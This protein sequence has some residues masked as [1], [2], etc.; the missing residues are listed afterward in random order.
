MKINLKNFAGITYLLI[1]SFILRLITIYYYGDDSLEHEWSTLLKNLHNHSTLSFRSFNGVLIPSVYM[2]P[3]Y[4]F[5]LYLIKILTPQS[6]AFTQMVLVFQLVLSILS[7]YIFFKLNNFFFNKN[8]SL[9]NSFLLSIFPLNIYATTQISSVTLQLF[10]LIFF[11]YLFFCLYKSQ[12]YKK[13][14]LFYFSLVSGLLIL[15]RGEFYLIFIF[16]LLYLL[17]FKKLNIKYIIIIFLISVIVISPYIIRNYYVFNKITLTK[18]LGYNLWKGNNPFATVE[19]AETIDAFA[20]NNINE[21]IEN[22][23]KDNLYDFHYDEMFFN[24]AILYIQKDPLVFATRFIKRGLSF[25]YF[26]LDS[27]YPNYYHPL[28][29]LPIFLVSFLSSIGIIISFKKMDFDKGFLLLYLFSHILIFSVFFILPRYK[30]V[31]LPIQLIF[32]NYFI[33]E[34]FRKISFLNKLFKIK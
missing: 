33:L 9:F 15:L 12:N 2:P 1:L 27:N 17:F 22:L 19:G 26:N 28:F 16:S 25:F 14:T 3:L 5:F 29:I 10:L 24:E 6:F 7:I 20:D 4:V 18:S 11:L 21:K 30:M 13:S 31:I 34:L 23:P 8:L 32:M